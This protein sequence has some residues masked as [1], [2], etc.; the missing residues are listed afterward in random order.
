MYANY[1]L[2]NT[3]IKI[4]YIFSGIVLGVISPYPTVIIVIN[5]KYM[6]FTYYIYEFDS[7]INYEWSHVS[8]D[9]D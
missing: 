2:D 1:P 7:S 4:T 3:V 9:P 6:L 5:A 8:V